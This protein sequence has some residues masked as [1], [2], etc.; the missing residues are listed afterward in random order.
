AAIAAGDL[1]AGV[2]AAILARYI[3]TVIWGLSVQ[4]AGGATR[5]QLEEVAELAMRSWPAESGSGW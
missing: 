3:I 4:A 5:A 2:D 1:P